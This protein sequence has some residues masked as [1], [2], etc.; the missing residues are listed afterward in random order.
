MVVVVIVL[1]VVVV[2]V[3]GRL[4]EMS[5]IVLGFLDVLLSTVDTV[6]PET[7]LASVGLRATGPIVV[8]CNDCDN[9]V[10]CVRNGG[11]GDGVGLSCRPL[12]RGKIVLMVGNLVTVGG[13][14]T[15]L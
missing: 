8:G 11:V 4:E 15:V 1:P 5:A 14:T 6:V 2:N 3:A 12:T 13:G 7:M 10:D 9:G